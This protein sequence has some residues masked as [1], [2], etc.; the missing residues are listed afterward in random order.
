MLNI[1]LADDDPDDV[2][3]FMH[4]LKYAHIEHELMQVKSGDELGTFISNLHQPSPDVIFLDIN[5]P[6]RNGKECLV[7]IRKDSRFDEVPVVMFTTSTEL[8]D[9]EETFKAGA[10]LYIS[11]PFDFSHYAPLIRKMF[12][13]GWKDRLLHSSRQTFVFSL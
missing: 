9:I 6:C 12:A 3:L 7:L 10:N 13:P 1:L 4:A 11:K 2:S 8:D 5:M